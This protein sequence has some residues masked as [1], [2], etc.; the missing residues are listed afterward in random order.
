MTAVIKKLTLIALLAALV[1]CGGGDDPA[2][3]EEATEQAED[4]AEDIS[5]D[6][7]DAEDIIVDT[8]SDVVTTLADVNGFK[9][10]T[11]TFNPHADNIYGT[12]VE[13]TAFVK[14]HSNNPVED[15]TVISFVADDLGLVEDQCITTGGTCFVT[16]TSAGDRS[17]PGDLNAVNVESDNEITIMARTI[18]EDS[19]IDKNSNS[20]FD[21][22]ETTFTQS[23]PYLDT[24]DDGDYDSGANDFDEFFDY[25]SN[26]VFDLD[27]VFTT[28]RGQSCSPGAIALGHCAGQLEVWDTV[29]MINS[30]G[31]GVSLTLINCDGSAATSPL[32]LSVNGCFTLEFKDP[33]GNIPPIGTRI[34]IE[35]D[36]GSIKFEP[37]ATVPNSRPAIGTGFVNDLLIADD[38]ITVDASA[39]LLTIEIESL[40]GTLTYRTFDI[41]D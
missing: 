1:A 27:T 7:V 15:G 29:T 20:L 17:E 26:G 24:N 9:I 11:T 14:D 23:E 12:R 34:S 21:V 2:A 35:S 33:N 37:P 28:F 4:I 22:G 32:D 8:A 38:D 19:F 18:G 16:W 13:I 36:V 25:N 39:G 5:I 3:V 30:N 41:D 6:G 10:V 40:D 31:G